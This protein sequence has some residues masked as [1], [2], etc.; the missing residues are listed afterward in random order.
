[1]Q[2]VCGCGRPH[3]PVQ[4]STNGHTQEHREI[5]HVYDYVTFEVVRFKPKGFAQRRKDG[6]WGLGSVTPHLYRRPELLAADPQEVVLISEG[7]KDV[8][9]ARSLG[10]VSITNPMGAGKWRE[11]YSKD[12]VG[13]LVVIIPD[14]DPPGQHHAQQVAASCSPPCRQRT[15]AEVARG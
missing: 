4:A 14:N 9:S 7:E 1:L 2:G 3:N 6:Q 12:L 10:Y 5:A 15:D 8:E 11:S 13:R